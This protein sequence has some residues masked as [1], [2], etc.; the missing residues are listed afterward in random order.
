MP[1][2]VVVVGND[3]VASPAREEGVSVSLDEGS[4]VDDASTPSPSS[5]SGTAI[6]VADEARDIVVDGTRHETS[7]IEDAVVAVDVPV[8]ARLPWWWSGR[9][10]SP[11]PRLRQDAFLPDAALVVVVTVSGASS[12]GTLA[13][14]ELR[15]APRMRRHFHTMTTQGAGPALRLRG[16]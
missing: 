8:I 2:L 15:I 12:T 4:S 14:V 6:V 7:V 16:R 9:S 3:D 13:L 5:P 1:G 11:V 10:G